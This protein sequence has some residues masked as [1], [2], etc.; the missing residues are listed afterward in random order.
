[1][2]KPPWMHEK[3]AHIRIPKALLYNEKYCHHLSPEAL[4]LYGLMM[5][6]TSLSMKCRDKHFCLPDGTVTIIFTQREAMQLLHC[7]RDKIRKIWIYWIIKE[8]PS[9][10][11]RRD[12][13]L[14]EVWLTQADQKALDVQIQLA[15][16]YKDCKRQ[17]QLVAVY[18]SGTKDLTCQTSDLLCYNKKRLAQLE[19]QQAKHR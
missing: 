5:D 1:M 4:V 3:Y 9:M 17:G 16:L 7:K 10:E 18:R 13:K 14:V 2:K 8:V 6:R 11:I 12:G 15:E 19:V